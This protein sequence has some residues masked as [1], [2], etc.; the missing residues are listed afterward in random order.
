MET[1]ENANGEEMTTQIIK[2]SKRRGF[3]VTEFC[4]GKG[5]VKYQ[6]TQKY[7]NKDGCN[8]DMRLV[9]GYV[10]LSKND[11]EFILKQID[12]EERKWKKE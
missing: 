6:I 9:Y 2:E 7:E 11:L 3:T 1:K 12:I 5:K 8:N 4:A 10:H